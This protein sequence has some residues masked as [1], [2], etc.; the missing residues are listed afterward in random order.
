MCRGLCPAGGVNAGAWPHRPPPLRAAARQ[1][2][3]RPPADLLPPPP[4]PRQGDW[5][6]AAHGRLQSS[7]LPGALRFLRG[8]ACATLWSVLGREF[9]ATL[10]ESRWWN[11]ISVRHRCEHC[12]GEKG[13]VQTACLRERVSTE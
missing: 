12:K 10:L 7:L 3:P 13:A 6:E 8:A 9:N 11:T 5:D 2:P 4:C 1:M